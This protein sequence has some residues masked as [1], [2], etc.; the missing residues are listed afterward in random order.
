M[1]ILEPD[2]KME[3]QCAAEENIYLASLGFPE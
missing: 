1:K 3:V 2:R